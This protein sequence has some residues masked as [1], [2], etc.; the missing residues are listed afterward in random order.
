MQWHSYWGFMGVQSVTSRLCGR[1]WINIRDANVV[2]HK[3][4]NSAHFTS[5]LFYTANYVGTPRFMDVIR[6][7]WFSVVAEAAETLPSF[8]KPKR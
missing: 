3:S 7:V 4:A 6:H 8:W 1:V 5:I 2:V